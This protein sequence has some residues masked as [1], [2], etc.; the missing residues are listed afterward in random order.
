MDTPSRNQPLYKKIYDDIE[1]KISTGQIAYMEQLPALQELCRLYGVS[2][3]PV[4]QA[5]SE[6]ER[7]HLVVKQRG[8]GKGTF[9]IKKLTTRTMRVLLMDD[10]DIYRNPI[11]LVHEMFDILAGMR[12]TARNQ[13]TEIQLISPAS[14]DTLS[15]ASGNTGYLILAQGLDG[16]ERGLKIAASHNV[17]SVLVNPPVAL[18]PCVRVDMEE[19]AYLGVNYLAQL[20]HR[21]IAYVGGTQGEWLAPRYAGYLRALNKNLLAVDTTLVCESNGITSE[22]DE[23]ALNTLMAL[24]SPPTAIF[25]TTDYRALHLLAHARRRGIA[26][27]QQ[28]SLCGYDNISEVAGVEPALTTV[29]HPRFELGREAVQLLSRLLD[30]EKVE[31]TDVLVPPNVVI[32]ASC[33]SPRR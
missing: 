9:A 30:D 22:Q 23:T 21:R 20:G 14:H 18:T 33:I 3:A 6:L 24:D 19:A 25:A 17:P 7:A 31:Q 5:L 15:L 1:H 4:R 26:I 10:I 16:Y 12:A 13:S 8:R 28:L 27:P 2:E 29:H 32:R 11:E